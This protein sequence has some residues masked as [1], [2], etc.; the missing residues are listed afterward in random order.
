MSW[1]D[2]A[3]QFV[4]SLFIYFVIFSAIGMLFYFLDRR[5]RKRI[6]R[7]VRCQF[8]GE[9]VEIGLLQREFGKCPACGRRQTTV[10]TREDQPVDR[11][12]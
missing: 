9:E 11:G 6:S 1:L 4:T 7:T 8:C 10:G 5:V 2:Q 12:A 3:I